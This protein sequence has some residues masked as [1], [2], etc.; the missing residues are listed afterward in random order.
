MLTKGHKVNTF[1]VVEAKIK[2]E[3]V[4][5]AIKDYD[6]ETWHK[7]LGHIGENELEILARK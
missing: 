7:R 3:Y 5:V 4:N 6:I 2:K 1:Y